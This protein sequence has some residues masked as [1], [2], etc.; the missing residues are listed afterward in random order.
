MLKDIISFS[1]LKFFKTSSV[2]KISPIELL[3]RAKASTPYIS[4]DFKL[5][6]VDNVLAKLNLHP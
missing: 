2:L 6:L 1:L 5:T 4:L 3:K